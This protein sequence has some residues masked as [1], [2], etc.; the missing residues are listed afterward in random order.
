M[1]ALLPFPNVDPVLISFDVMG[2]TL[3]IHW[4]AIAYIAGFVCAW[5]WARLLISRLG[6]WRNETPPISAPQVEDLMTWMI[7]GTI[8]GG[9]LGYVLFYQFSDFITDPARIL[10]VW[11]GGMSFHGGFIGVVIAGWI[12][13]RKARLSPWSAGDLIAS[14]ACFGLFFGRIANFVNAELWGR[15]TDVPW[16]VA[17]PTQAAQECGQAIGQLCGRHPSQ[18]YEALLEGPALFLLI[19]T[20]I[21]VRRWLV[22]PGKIVG[23]FFV[24]Y[25]TARTVV[26]SFRQ[27]DPQFISD[28]NPLGHII[29]LGDFGLTMG[30]LLSLP[31][32]VIGLAIIILRSRK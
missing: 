29:R 26:E 7:I 2:R 12:Y 11:E 32:I 31:M 25:G 28:Q 13:C 23:L 9:R 27:A 17:F 6:L 18:L 19:V 14:S 24:G 16:A 22:K 15:P 3:A 21:F 10:R 8:L 30:Q 20:F 1:L 5:M 4:Y